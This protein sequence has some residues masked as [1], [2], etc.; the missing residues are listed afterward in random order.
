MCSFVLS[1]H[2]QFRALQPSLL[3][4]AFEKWSDARRKSSKIYDNSN[5]MWEPSCPKRTRRGFSEESHRLTVV[6]RHFLFVYNLYVGENYLV[7]HSK[8]DQRRFLWRQPSLIQ[9]LTPTEGEIRC[10]PGEMFDSDELQKEVYSTGEFVDK[11]RWVHWEQWQIWKQ[12]WVSKKKCTERYMT[13]M[14]IVTVARKCLVSRDD[15]RQFWSRPDQ[16]H[17]N[18]GRDANCIS[19]C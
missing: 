7:C 9:G 17:D 2:Y 4:C 8:L 15:T 3:F 11:T 6:Y 19:R 16:K 18:S 1:E 5:N 10:I 13:K 12:V 14:H